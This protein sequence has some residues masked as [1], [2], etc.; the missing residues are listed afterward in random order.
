MRVF[1]AAAEAVR[2]GRR[3]VMATVI[4]VGGSTP[5]STSARMLVFDDGEIVG[6]IGGGAVEH[7]VIS[8]ALECMAVGK[9]RRWSA[10]LTRDLGMC[11]GGRMEVYLEPLMPR[12]PFVVF[13]AGHVAH[14]LV[15]FLCALDFDV[16]VVDSRDD[17]NTA[18]RFPTAR[19]VHDDG[20][21]Y[22]AEIAEDEDA[23]WLI[24]THDHGLDQDILELLLP[25]ACA[26]LGMIGSKAKVA[27]F[28]VRLMGAGVDQALF[29]KLS[30]PVGLD[31]GA[32][33]PAEIA[34]AIAAEV[35]RVRRQS[36]TQPVPLSEHAL[37][38]R[39]GDGRAVPP[40]LRE[41]R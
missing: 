30:A 27:R 19:R 22:A 38:A 18:E 13:G 5:R 10:D 7:R 14:A 32:E 15:P 26:W 2:T 40:R 1:A 8:A 11:C 31:V 28:L 3:A 16:V 39:G 24:V 23:Y 36:H 4:D 20:R 41:R 21:A 29:Q 33:T 9:S 35:V 34:V 17:L 37:E 25:K 12:E 6:T